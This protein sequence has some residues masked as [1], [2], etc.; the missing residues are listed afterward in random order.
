MAADVPSLPVP[1]ITH[2][3]LKKLRQAAS[4]T[5]DALASAL[6]LDRSSISKIE[7]GNRE[8]TFTEAQQWTAAC[9]R[10]LVLAG[11]ERVTTFTPHERRAAIALRC[12]RL[13]TYLEE[14]HLITLEALIGTWEQVDSG[15]LASSRQK[16]VK[17]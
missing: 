15:A 10:A 4:L 11:D 3:D 1:V 17:G 16:L 2:H 6:S 12:S 7:S 8:I 5:Q 13:I 14:P 9:G